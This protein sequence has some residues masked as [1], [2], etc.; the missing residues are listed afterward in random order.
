MLAGENVPFPPLTSASPRLLFDFFRF[1][2]PQGLR[3]DPHRTP[4]SQIILTVF[5]RSSVSL[6]Q[7]CLSSVFLDVDNHPYS[8]VGNNGT[9][10]IPVR[11][12]ESL[13][14]TIKPISAHSP[15]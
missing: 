6:V 10:F 12:F 4:Q 15:E 11:F 14:T 3:K 7:F 5:L 1:D 2:E 8:N 13:S 9:T